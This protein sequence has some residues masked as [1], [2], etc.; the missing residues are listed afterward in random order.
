MRP[1]WVMLV[2]GACGFRLEAQPGDAPT[3]DTAI[4]A[5]I[6][7]SVTS[8][9]IGAWCH[10]KMITIHAARVSGGPHAGIP[11][12]IDLAADADLAATARP[13]GFDLRFT[14][15]DGVTPLPYDRQR[16]RTTGQLL[17]WVQI[18]IL[19]ASADT[20][21][22]LYYGN[23]AATDQQNA[24]AVWASYQGVWHL[25]EGAGAL[26]VTDTTPNAN[27]GVGVNG[28][29]LSASGKIGPG[30]SFDGVDDYLEMPNSASLDMSNGTA[31]IGLWVNWTATVTSHF[32]RVLISSNRFGASAEGYELAAQ[33]G[34]DFFMYPWG[35]AE[36]YCL[37]S[38]P[39]TVQTWQYLVATLQFA[40]QSVKIYVDGVPM[41]YTT[42]NS[43]Q[44]T[45][46][47]DPAA[48]QWGGTSEG[49]QLDNNFGGRMDEL[50]VARFVRS[51]DWILTEFRNQK[52]PA[53][54]Y[55]VGLPEVLAP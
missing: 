24:A 33:P 16:Y 47:G 32:Q 3:A 28:P 25:D 10:R 8:N 53:T 13:D 34:G 12:L 48:W 1:V 54:F 30:V 4:D 51:A 43:A 45:M 6:D 18:P 39:F 11:I 22:Y 42:D 20:I 35:G 41:L 17:A 55:A 2:V 14:A 49:G 29:T 36:S 44:W 50:R 26:A 31:T 9:C 15:A 46:L 27:H 38:D 5:A 37:G 19:S 52:T 40:T 23:P 7:A 21:I